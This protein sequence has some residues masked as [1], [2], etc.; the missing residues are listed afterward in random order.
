LGS[1]NKLTGTITTEFANAMTSFSVHFC[2]DEIKAVTS[3]GL[4]LDKVDSFVA[5]EEIFE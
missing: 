5:T 4:V 1:T 3:L 2:I